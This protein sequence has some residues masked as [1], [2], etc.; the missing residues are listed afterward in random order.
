MSVPKEGQR[1]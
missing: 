1:K